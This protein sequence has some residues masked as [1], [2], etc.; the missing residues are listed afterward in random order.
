MKNLL[1]F[2]SLREETFF[3]KKDNLELMLFKTLSSKIHQFV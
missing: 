3:L 2:K 1:V